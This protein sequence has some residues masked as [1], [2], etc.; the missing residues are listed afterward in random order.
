MQFFSRRGCDFSANLSP[1]YR[2][3]FQTCSKFAILRRFLINLNHKG[4]LVGFYHAGFSVCFCMVMANTGKK[5]HAFV[6]VF[7]FVEHR[8]Q[9]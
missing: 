8:R 6:Y 5:K 1:R 2:K 4:P 3:N 7:V 9:Y